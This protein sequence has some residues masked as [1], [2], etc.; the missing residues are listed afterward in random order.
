MID[1]QAGQIEQT[2][3]PAD[4]KNDMQRLEPQIIAEHED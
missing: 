2:G 4:H 3:K 1:E